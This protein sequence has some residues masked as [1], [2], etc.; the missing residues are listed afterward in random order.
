ME[1][2]RNKHLS[3]RRYLRH[4]CCFFQRLGP[5]D[6]LIPDVEGQEGKDQDEQRVQADDP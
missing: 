6:N 5:G 3:D 2:L 4:G 1:F